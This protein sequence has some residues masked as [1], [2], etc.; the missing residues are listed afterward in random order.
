MECP[1][2]NTGFGFTAE[3]PDQKRANKRYAVV[4]SACHYRVSAST[5]TKAV[6]KWHGKQGVFA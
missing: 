5:P 1:R 4:C 3:F 6:R 2:C